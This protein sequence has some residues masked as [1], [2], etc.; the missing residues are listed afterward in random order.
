MATNVPEYF[1]WL[2]KRY[3][4]VDRPTPHH[5]RLSLDGLHRKGSHKSHKGDA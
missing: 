5:K 3:A 1:A 4:T 2:S